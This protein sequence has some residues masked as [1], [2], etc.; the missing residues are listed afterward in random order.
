MSDL[1]A[2]QEPLDRAIC[3]AL[4]ASVPANWNVIMLTL[5]GPADRDIGALAHS[6][7][8]PEGHFPV[9]PHELL[10]EATRRL[11]ELFRRFGTVFVKATYLV[12]ISENSWHYRAD[13]EYSCATSA[14]HQE[15]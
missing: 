1:T 6:I 10:F 13:F 8:S 3:D 14:S 5:S 2:L 9:L 4:V 12:E 7:C 11:D 15:P